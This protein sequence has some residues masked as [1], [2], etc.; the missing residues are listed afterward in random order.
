MRP[1]PVERSRKKKNWVWECSSVVEHLPNMQ[2]SLGLI[3][4]SYPHREKKEEEK[5][6]RGSRKDDM[7]CRSQN[8]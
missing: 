8:L 1:I 7:Q 3:L 2:E 6:E 5:V 4:S